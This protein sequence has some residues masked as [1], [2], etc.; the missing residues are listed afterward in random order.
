IPVFCDSGFVIL[1]SLKK[2]VAKRAKVAVASMAIALSTGLFAT[3]TLVPPTT[4]PLA[5]GG[6]IGAEKYL[7]T[8]SLICIIVALPAM[9]AGYVWAIKVCTNMRIE[10]EERDD[11]AYDYDPIL[12]ECGEM[13][14]SLKSFAPIVVPILLIR[15]VSVITF[16]GWR[17]TMFDV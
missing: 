1:S 16:V 4:G 15:F 17:G 7:G 2:A 14:S 3:H 12:K 11:L 6:N 5:V 13:P 8:I 9:I 10:G